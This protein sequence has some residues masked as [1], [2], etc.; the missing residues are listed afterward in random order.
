M[1]KKKK[2]FFIFFAVVIVGIIFFFEK[3]KDP[4]I[5]RPYLSVQGEKIF[6]EIADTEQKRE[7]GLSGRDSIGENE[8]MM[9]LFSEKGKYGFWMKGMSFP[10]DIIWINGNSVVGV[11]KNVDPQVGALEEELKVYSPSEDVDRVLEIRGGKADELGINI[12]DVIDT[13]LYYN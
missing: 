7:Q 6:V 12:G 5:V 2:I 8:G 4:N 1:N 9:F 3:G 10:I 13:V 11:E